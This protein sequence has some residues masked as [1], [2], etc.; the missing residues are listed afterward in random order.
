VPRQAAPPQIPAGGYVV[1]PGAVPP[2]YPP[3]YPRPVYLQPP[4]LAPNGQP[5]A[6]FFS[7]LGAYLLD[8]LIM[9]AIASVFWVPLVIWW[10]ISFVTQ[11][12]TVQT[13]A[14]GRLE[15]NVRNADFAEFFLGYLLLVAAML[16]ITWAVSYVYLVEFTWRTG[17]TIGKRVVKLK[18]VPADPAAERTRGMLAKRWLVEQ[19]AALI[20]FF[21]YVDGLWQLWD[22]PLQQCL[23][24]KA[25]KTVVVKIG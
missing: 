12:E 21:S 22:K 1:P 9:G 15:P 6:D 4:P 13:S 10:I 19:V 24:D 14:D 8:S 2:G 18:I 17:Q 5:L 23:H 16:L 3:G 11:V 25:A 20:P 7:R